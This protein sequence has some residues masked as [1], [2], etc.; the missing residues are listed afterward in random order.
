MK[1]AMKFSAIGIILLTSASLQA[2]VK[3]KAIE[4]IQ[5]FGLHEFSCTVAGK[6]QGAQSIHF[7]DTLHVFA[8][9]DSEAVKICLNQINAATFAE[10]SGDLILLAHMHDW[11][12]HPVLIEDISI[13]TEQM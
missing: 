13:R 1:L 11:S 2:D 9:N 12:E 3:F 8:A 6:T 10:E 5:K 4:T 7:S